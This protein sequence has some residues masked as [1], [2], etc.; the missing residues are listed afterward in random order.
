VYDKGFSPPGMRGS[1]RDGASPRLSAKARG[2]QDR[3]VKSSLCRMIPIR[4]PMALC[5][6]A[7]G[8]ET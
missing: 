1:V 3:L 8:G 6:T 5:G 7:A 2:L 4:D